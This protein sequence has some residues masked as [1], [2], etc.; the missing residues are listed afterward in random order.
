MVTKNGDWTVVSSSSTTS[1]K[2]TNGGKK[3]GNANSMRKPNVKKGSGSGFNIEGNIS[4]EKKTSPKNLSILATGKTKNNR[5]QGR[6]KFQ[7]QE[8]RKRK[9]ENSEKERRRQNIIGAGF[10]INPKTK[11]NLKISADVERIKGKGN[12]QVDSDNWQGAGNWKE[13]ARYLASINAELDM[14]GGR[15]SASI[16]RRGKDT[17]GMLRFSYPLGKKR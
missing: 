1:Y 16:S 7:T 9:K 15:G 2:G 13:K 5:L 6:L 8:T 3:Y 10:T 4:G 11:D 14:L 12:W 17:T